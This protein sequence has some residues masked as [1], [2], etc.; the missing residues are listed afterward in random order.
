MPDEPDDG[1]PVK[2]K[3]HVKWE[4]SAQM[5]SL[6]EVDGGGFRWTCMDTRLTAVK[7]YKGLDGWGEEKENRNPQAIWV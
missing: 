1:S 5:N 6:A 3:N 7:N 4:G 2:N